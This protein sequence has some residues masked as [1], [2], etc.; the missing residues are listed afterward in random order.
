[1]KHN[2]MFPGGSV[3]KELTCKVGGMG[4][5]PGL[6]SAPGERKWQP[7]P[8]FL[9]GKSSEQRNLASYCPWGWKRVGHDLATE[10][11]KLIY[12]S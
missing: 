8:V 7:T 11:Q 6:G 4:L 12:Y 10:Q 3:V 1:M 5:T 2:D 9:L